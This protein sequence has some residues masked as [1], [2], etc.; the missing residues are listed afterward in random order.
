MKKVPAE[1]YTRVVG[2]YRPVNQWNPGKTEELRQ[3][4]TYKIPGGLSENRT[5]EEGRGIIRESR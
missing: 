3:R 1:V 2:F 4:K 5:L